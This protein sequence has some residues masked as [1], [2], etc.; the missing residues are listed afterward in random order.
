MNFADIKNLASNVANLAKVK[1]TQYAPEILMG[2]GIVSGGATVVLACKATLNVED[3]LDDANEKME[4]I[5]GAYS[6]ELKIKEGAEYS[7]ADYRQDK[8]VVRVQTGVALAKLYAPAATTAVLSVACVLSAYGI[9]KKRNVALLGLYKASEKAL[10]DYR[11]R[12]A[13]AVGEEKEH[14]IYHG[15]HEEK[16][17]EE[18]TDEKGKV[19]KVKTK[20]KVADPHIPSPYARF[21]DECNPNWSKSPADNKYLLECAQNQLNNL[22]RARQIGNPGDHGYKP[23]VVFLNEAYDMLGFD[24]T[25]AGQYVGWTSDTETGDG[26]I[27]FFMYEDAYQKREFINGYERSIL[28]DFNV[29]GVVADIL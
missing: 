18:V 12:V 3:I 26:F 22:L 17:E 28:L 4:K 7:E 24:R 11:K 5:E 1:T 20:V 19:K 14:D 29:D 6:G 8:F 25:E 10:R 23:G 13:E 27:E 16:I 21:F 15:L 2:V 9:L